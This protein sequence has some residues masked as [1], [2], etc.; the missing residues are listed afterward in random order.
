MSSETGE[1]LL[2]AVAK[3]RIWIEELVA[4]RVASF[5]ELA[6]REGKAER[7]IRLLAPLAFVSPRIIPQIIDG[8][9]PPSLTVIGLAKGLGYSW[10]E[11][12]PSDS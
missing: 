4:G 6:E 10:A 1:S 2:G 11:H 3:A 12:R 9:A 7:H 5:A 8:G